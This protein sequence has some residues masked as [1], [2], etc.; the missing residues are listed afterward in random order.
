[1]V[2]TKPRPFLAP[3]CETHF[4]LQSNYTKKCLSLPRG[5]PAWQLISGF[6]LS[7]FRRIQNYLF[8]RRK[9]FKIA[10]AARRSDATERLR[11][12]AIMSFHDL[13]DL[14]PLQHAQMPAQVAVGERAQLLEI[15]EGQS[16]GIT[17]QR[18]EHAEPR[19]LV[20]HPV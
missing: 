15:A 8:E 3:Y 11:T 2:T 6:F 4:A 16:F 5:H 12:I 1:M 9:V 10:F 17:D 7:Y 13:H 19:P 14:L 20:N 18:G